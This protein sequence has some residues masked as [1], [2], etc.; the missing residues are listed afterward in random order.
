MNDELVMILYFV[1]E[2]K[3]VR[4]AVGEDVV[5]N[6]TAVFLQCRL[7]SAVFE[8]ILEFVKKSWNDE[9]GD[10]W[11]DVECHATLAEYIE[12]F[13]HESRKSQ[14]ASNNLECIHLFENKQFE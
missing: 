5:E 1:H 10:Y 4:V 3:L 9:T 11:M 8:N 6:T 14:D 13:I 2:K 12:A 7:T